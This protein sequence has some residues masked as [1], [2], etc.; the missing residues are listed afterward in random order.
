MTPAQQIA[1]W[2]DK[3][4]DIS[5][6]GGHFAN[7]VYDVENYRSI[8]RISVEML[9]LVSSNTVEEIEPLQATVL[10]RPTPYAVGDAATFDDDGRLLLIQRADN[11]KWALPGGVLDVGETPA[12]GVVREALEETGYAC[13][14]L[15]LIGVFDSRHAQTES[16]H[17]M[18]HFQFLCHL[19]PEIERV[20]PTHPHETL[21]CAWFAEADLPTKI[22]PGHAT[23]IP[24]A[25]AAWR[26]ELE[27]FFDRD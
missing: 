15:R 13:V 23:R 21:D 26:G 11:G 5:A 6:R 20:A 8:Q 24:Y 14:A 7:N 22:D 19:R 27:A 3:L 16:V 4:R 2:A 18:Y 9:A 10:N 17:H 1:L 12:Q 25:F